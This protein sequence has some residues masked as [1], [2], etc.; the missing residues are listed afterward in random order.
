[1]PM[2]GIGEPVADV[3]DRARRRR[4]RCS[5]STA[6]TRSACVTRQRRARL[7]RRPA[8]DER[9]RTR[10][11]SIAGRRL[12]D[13]ARSTP[14]RT[15]IRSTGAVVT[16]IS[17]ATTFAQAA[18]GEHAGFEYAPHRQPHARARSRTC[19]GVARGR[20]A[21]PRVR[22][23]AWPRRTR[24]SALLG[25]GDHVV[26]PDDAYGGTFRL[27]SKVYAPAGHRLERRP[28]SPTSDALE[29][30]WRDE[31]RARVG[32]DA[33][34]PDAHDRRHR[35]G[36][37]R[38]R[39]SAARC[40]VVD[41]TFATPYLQQPLEL[42]ADIVVHSTTKYLGGHSDVV[43]GFVALDDDE[44]AERARV[45]AERGRRGAV[46]VRLLPRAA[47]ASRRSRCAWTG[48]AR[49]PAAI[50]GDARR[51]TRP[52][53]A[54]CTPGCPTTRARRS[55]RRQMRD[56]GGMVSFTRRGRRGRPRSTSWRGP[57]CSRWPSRSARSSR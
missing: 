4:R 54:S 17:L 55:P 10:E 39:T 6:A 1:M 35:G 18:V 8:P 33:D 40:V 21:R 11:R 38:S 23:R 24:C 45:R 50:V 37:A 44:L 47:R 56:F 42:G 34:E 22:E 29:A 53:T 30:A 57:G 32:R 51:R 15:P 43:G 26:I 13:R 3:V 48:T 2:V 49:T 14:A 7:P 52:S 20:G 9:R 16:P 41:N 28:T 46:A 12:R 27:V 25:P 36:R 19:L 31:T 5:C